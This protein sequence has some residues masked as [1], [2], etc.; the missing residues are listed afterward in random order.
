MKKLINKNNIIIGVIVLILCAG[1]TN[2]I[3]FR[4]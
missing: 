3:Y 4:K 2:Y 1:L